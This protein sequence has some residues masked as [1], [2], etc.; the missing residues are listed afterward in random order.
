V[1]PL[2]GD[3]STIAGQV[4]GDVTHEVTMRYHGGE[5]PKDRIKFGERVLEIRRVL[6][7]NELNKK[8]VCLCNEVVT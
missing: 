5:S 6:N 8:I 4:V 2:T 3:E 7:V 1:V